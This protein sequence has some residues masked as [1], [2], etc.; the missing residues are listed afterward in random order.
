[1]VVGEV[2][3]NGVGAE[4]LFC[5]THI[6]FFSRPIHKRGLSDNKSG[7]LVVKYGGK[8]GSKRGRG[9]GDGIIS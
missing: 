7:V 3:G 1:M 2:S 6:I 9:G 4:T 5:R 8:K